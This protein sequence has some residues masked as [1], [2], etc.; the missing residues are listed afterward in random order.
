MMA[1]SMSIAMIYQRIKQF[2]ILS[3]QFIC[4]ASFRGSLPL[5]IFIISTLGVLS[6]STF[7][8]LGDPDTFLHLKIGQWIISHQAVPM[9][10]YFSHSLPGESWVA[11]EWL[12]ELIL[13][14]VYQI[15]GWGGLVL[16]AASCLGLSLALLAMFLQRRMPPIYALLFTA[17]AFFAVLPLPLVLVVV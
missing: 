14:M 9:V 13:L 7:Q 17:L 6:F 16:L 10:D 3:K 2:S 8:T 4:S 5:I 1:R 12:S 11:H 15:G